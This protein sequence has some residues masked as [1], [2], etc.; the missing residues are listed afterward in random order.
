MSL[1]DRNLWIPS[2]VPQNLQ[3]PDCGRTSKFV[4]FVKPD[5]YEYSCPSCHNSQLLTLAQINNVESKRFHRVPTA[6]IPPII[7]AKAPHH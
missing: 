2:R 7:T 4:T 1:P 6:A 5:H 3:C